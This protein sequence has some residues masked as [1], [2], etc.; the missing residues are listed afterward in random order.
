MYHYV[1]FILFIFYDL[2]ATDL[3]NLVLAVHLH[4]GK[5]SGSEVYLCQRLQFA[6]LCH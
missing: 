6:V 5:A 4:Q 1:L 2:V 3:Y